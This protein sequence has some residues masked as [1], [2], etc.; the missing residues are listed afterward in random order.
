MNASSAVHEVPC[1]SPCANSRSHA[2]GAPPYVGNDQ[3]RHLRLRKLGEEHLCVV[4][5]CRRDSKCGLGHNTHRVAHQWQLC[6]NRIGL[7]QHCMLIKRALAAALAA[8]PGIQRRPCWHSA[9]Q[10]HQQSTARSLTNP[11]DNKAVRDGCLRVDMLTFGPVMQVHQHH[12]LPESAHRDH[13][14][15]GT[16]NLA[17]L[18]RGHNVELGGAPDVREPCS[19]ITADAARLARPIVVLPGCG[20]KNTHV[21]RYCTS[22]KQLERCT[23]KSAI[24]ARACGRERD[25]GAQSVSKRVQCLCYRA[26]HTALGRQHT[27]TRR[28][29]ARTCTQMLQAPR[30]ALAPVP[31]SAEPTAAGGHT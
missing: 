28:A 27:R 7:L 12:V 15:T 1:R 29:P 13:R 20:Q 19:L 17:V 16:P 8:T 22:T 31:Q 18:R 11:H 6:H 23:A 2:C 30:T 5:Q 4:Q 3:R 14:A 26:T 21:S 24:A 10:P 9:V 25:A